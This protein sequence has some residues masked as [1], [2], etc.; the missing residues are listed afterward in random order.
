[1]RNIL[2]IMLLCLSLS[3][4]PAQR[5]SRN[6][7]D[8]SLSEV[9]KNLSNATKRYDISFI[10]NEL[11]DFRVTARISRKTIPEAVHEVVGFYPMRI[12]VSDSIIT[13]ECTHKTNLHLKGRII[14]ENSKPLPYAN[15]A[16][17]NPADSVVIGGGVSNES[18]IFVIPLDKQNVIARIS[19]VG[20]KTVYK[21]CSREDIGTIKM[22]PDNYTL[23]GVTVKGQ[24]AIV[25]A[26]K[27]HLTYN[28]PQLMQIMPA[29]DAYEALKRIP[30]VAE[31]GDGKLTFTGHPL[32]LIING[33]PTTLSAEQVAERLKSMPASQLAKAEIMTAAPAKYHVRGMAINIVTKDYAGSNFFAGQLQASLIQS[34]YTRGN[35]KATFIYNQGKLGLDASYSVTDGKAYGKV[36]HEANHPLGDIRIPYYDKTTNKSDGTDHDYRI[37]MDYAFSE[38]NRLSI[39][40]TGQWTSTDAVNTTTGI[41]E[42][43]QNSRQHDYL[44]NVDIGYSTPFGL[45]LG[46]S[47]TNYQNPETQNLDGKMYDKVRQLTVDRRQKISKWLFTADQTHSLRNGWELSYGVKTQFTNNNSYQTTWDA[48][49]KEIADATSHIDYNERI[50]NVYAGF[51]K[52]I[53]S[54]LS[55]EGSIAGEQYHA[56]KWNEWR[57]YPAFSAMW[58]IDKNNM[59][60]L[61]FSSDAVYPSY[62]STMS[63]I[64]YT[65]SYSEIWGNPDLKPSSIYDLNLMWQLKRRYTFTAFAS[66]QPND[67]M[68]LAYQPSD[69]M[70]V[71]MKETNFDYSNLYGLQFSAQYSAG[72]WLNG[73]VFLT[74]LYRHDKS[75]NFFDL[76]FDRQKLAGIFGG[77][78]MLKLS[79]RH[80]ITLMLNPF[81][82]TRAIQGVYDID[83]LFYLNANLRWTSD[84]GKWSM[85]ASGNNIFNGYANTHSY[86]GN[87]DYSMR[88]WM[89]YTT[90][91]LTAIYRIGN[92]KEKK[93]KTVDTSRMGY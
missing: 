14:D 67:F 15:I 45:E 72:K 40:Y 21:H 61:S 69:R 35:A 90:F 46:A 71:I 41:A 75:N 73:T 68:Q 9:L 32:T 74:G 87:Q 19:Y 81:F 37:G 82:Q 1:M 11:E 64:Y 33:K 50:L 6:F 65:S 18:G 29:D 66:W 30:G 2:T 57:I 85:V 24:H 27:G 56:T 78:A 77:T 52:Q 34:K 53:N 63:G 10:Y 20:Y 22:Q 16:L 76:P 43:K 86:Y 7:N 80:N 47:Y 88:V 91:T 5:V 70:A 28:M 3:Q 39:A 60:N 23:K 26:E 51:S 54:S 58:N 12:S 49:H 93:T 62:W 59:L 13:V 48:E 38:N 79:A 55:I 44:H 36:E 89:R 31:T 25:K 8:V 92:F 84:S 42:S 83:P 4:T 17:L